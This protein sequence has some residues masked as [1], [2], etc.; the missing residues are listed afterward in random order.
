MTIDR[1][2]GADL[3]ACASQ[4]PAKEPQR[5][6][7]PGGQRRDHDLRRES[8]LGRGRD[9]GRN[10]EEASAIHLTERQL[11]VLA[12]LCEGL[13]NKHICRQLNIATGT[14]KVHISCILR[15]LEARSRLEAVVKAQRLGL[16]PAK[17][18]AVDARSQG[19]LARLLTNGSGPE[20]TAQAKQAAAATAAAG[21]A[22]AR[23]LRAAA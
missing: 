5:V 4:A 12:L 8:D 23:G 17:N 18:S 13:Q 10:G 3:Q 22:V 21:S 11:E 9:T 19:L 1:S 20:S 14:V 15:E 16:V 6:P 2:I 7:A